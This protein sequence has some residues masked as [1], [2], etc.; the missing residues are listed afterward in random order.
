MTESAH[1][2]IVLDETELTR[3]LLECRTRMEAE[4]SRMRNGS[5]SDGAVDALRGVVT[6]FAYVARRAGVPPERVLVLFKATVH[7]LTAI[8]PWDVVE[9]DALSR[10]LV[11]LTI[12]AY[13]G[14]TRVADA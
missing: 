1:H 12:E 6:D 8:Q 4:L 3:A 11:Q 14:S 2:D 7:A 13:Y 10:D 9:R 5:K